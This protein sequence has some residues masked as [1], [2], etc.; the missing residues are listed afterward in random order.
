MGGGEQT[1]KLR[2][3]TLRGIVNAKNPTSPYVEFDDV[4]NDNIVRKNLLYYSYNLIGKDGCLKPFRWFEFEIVNGSQIRSDRTLT[5]S[6]ELLPDYFK[7]IKDNNKLRFNV[8][9][10]TKN[11]EIPI[12]LIVED[13][14]YL[15][16]ENDT[17]ILLVIN[18]TKFKSYDRLSITFQI[19]NLKAYAS[20]DDK[21][22]FE[23]YIE[24]G[25]DEI[26]YLR[27]PKL[28][29]GSEMTDYCENES[30]KQNHIYSNCIQ[31]TN[32][33]T[34][35]INNRIDTLEKPKYDYNVVEVSFMKTT[36][37]G[38]YSNVFNSNIYNGY[39]NVNV[40]K[41][42]H[43]TL[44]VSIVNIN[45]VNGSSGLKYFVI[46]ALKIKGYNEEKLYLNGYGVDVIYYNITPSL[47]IVNIASKK[48]K[49]CV[50]TKYKES[51]AYSY[52]RID[53]N[54][55]VETSDNEKLTCIP[56][57]ILFNESGNYRPFMVDSSGRMMYP[58]IVTPTKFFIDAIHLSS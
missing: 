11:K 12:K 42:N 34:R 39:I 44:D 7:Y 36:L 56:V 6:F 17:T 13:N 18:R 3:Y 16:Q 32:Q 1:G 58:K 35:S 26:E 10:K 9:N 14:N 23:M 5:F 38:N 43:L 2:S 48:D 55:D 57:D 31:Y 52:Y 28:E 37:D 19:D 33:V 49:Q 41:Q 20:Y 25:G 51:G 45:T 21:L 54:D 46:P 15:L 53:S 40:A 4:N 8:K 47:N 30:M 29:L 50:L 27:N 24:N 22:L